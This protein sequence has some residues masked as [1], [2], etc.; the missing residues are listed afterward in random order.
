MLSLI[1]FLLSFCFILIPYTAARPSYERHLFQRSGNSSTTTYNT[2]DDSVA[3][4]RPIYL[5]VAYSLDD[6]TVDSTTGADILPAK[7]FLTI[8]GDATHPPITLSIEAVDGVSE[9]RIT[10]TPGNPTIERAGVAGT[11]SVPVILNAI[12]DATSA[13]L[14]ILSK[15]S[16]I[17]NQSSVARRD[18]AY[19][20]DNPFDSPPEPS[21]DVDPFIVQSSRTLVEVL[22]T[23]PTNNKLWTQMLIRAFDVVIKWSVG[24]GSL[25]DIA[26]LKE[27]IFVEV[28]PSSASLDIDRIAS[29]SFTKDSVQRISSADRFTAPR[30]FKVDPNRA[31]FTARSP[32]LRTPLTSIAFSNSGSDLT[33]LASSPPPMSPGADEVGLVRQETQY[34]DALD[35]FESDGDPIAAPGHSSNDPVSRGA[36]SDGV[37]NARAVS[38]ARVASFQI[39]TKLVALTVAKSVGYAA[40]GAAFVIVDFVHGDYVGGGLALAGTLVG[41]GIG[42]TF[43]IFLAE[44]GPIGWLVGAVVSALFFGLPGTIDPT[45]NYA[46]AGET[47]EIIQ[48]TFFGDAKVTGNEKCRTSTPEQTANPNCVAVYGPGLLAKLFNLP[49]FSIVAF[50]VHFNNG[51][52][53]TIPD[54]VNAFYTITPNIPHDGDDQVATINCHNAVAPH[55]NLGGPDDPDSDYCLKPSYYINLDLITLPVLNQTATQVKARL[56]PAPNADCRVVVYPEGQSFPKYNLTVSGLPSSIACGIHPGTNVSGALVN[57]D[58]SSGGGASLVSNAANST[59]N[60]GAAYIAPPPKSKLAPLTVAQGAICLGDTKKQTLCLPP[61]K[62]G[63]QSGTLNPQPAEQRG[64]PSPSVDGV[65]TSLINSLTLPVGATLT[66]DYNCPVCHGSGPNHGTNN[67]TTN[68]TITDNLVHPTALNTD[69]ATAAAETA[70]QLARQPPLIVISPG[71]MVIPSFCIFSDTNYNGM[72]WCAGLGGDDLPPQWRNKVKSIQLA[73]GTSV[74]MFPNSWADIDGTPISK[75]ASDLSAYPVGNS[76]QNFATN[77]VSIW[78]YVQGQKG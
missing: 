7:P 1:F 63:V 43:E 27:I 31:Q 14:G 42:L 6:R 34:F 66:I 58:G 53:M 24:K 2:T 41:V 33:H 12:D 78:A 13:F 50:L 67:Y 76:R 19:D 23:G 62:Y 71:N 77:F 60:T 15:L 40:I 47:Q 11:D 49:I 52:A 69:L 59:G 20:P 8:G 4:P 5:T 36:V 64:A 44:F 39:I 70:A 26:K 55:D 21:E 51:F 68:M 9:L 46:H 38:L 18:Y 65:S 37:A 48:Y 35:A 54:M 3:F 29:C 74:E 32:I 30:R 61:G 45:K 75:S 22:E 73:P 72:T 28:D 25:M 57:L 56:Y 17:N 16:S 10:R